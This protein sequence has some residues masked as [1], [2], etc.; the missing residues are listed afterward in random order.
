MINQL[1]RMRWT[2]LMAALIGFMVAQAG[3]EVRSAVLSVYD[4]VRPVVTL[5]SATIMEQG[6][7]DMVVGL[8]VRKARDCD[9]VRLQAFGAI[10]DE[11]MMDAYMRR[12][13]TPEKGTTR[14]RGTFNI[15]VWRIWPINGASSVIVYAQHDCGN[16][17]VQTRLADIDLSRGRP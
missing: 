8:V 13:D 17:I 3:Q 15:G 14:P 10:A 16:R 6:A 1:A 12:I 11:P 4:A 9:Y 5:V 2:I 7:D